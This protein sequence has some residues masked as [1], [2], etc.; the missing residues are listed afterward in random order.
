MSRLNQEFWGSIKI[1][2]LLGDASYVRRVFL[3]VFSSGPI[4]ANGRDLSNDKNGS[5]IFAYPPPVPRF[6]PKKCSFFNL[7]YF[8]RNDRLPPLHLR[9]FFRRTAFCIATWRPQLITF[10][11]G[12]TKNFHPNFI[13]PL[14]F[15]IWPRDRS[16]ASRPGNLSPAYWGRGL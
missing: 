10:S 4:T 1:T 3:K 5:A 2:A 6:L 9:F 8:Y 13:R 15:K 16:G 7:S 11:G 12:F 14:G